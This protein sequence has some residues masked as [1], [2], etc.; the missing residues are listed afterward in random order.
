LASSWF[1]V[2]FGSSPDYQTTTFTDYDLKGSVGT[3][4]LGTTLSDALAVLRRDNYLSLSP[5]DSNSAAGLQVLSVKRCAVI[6]T[7]PL[8]DT[9]PGDQD[10]ATRQLFDDLD[11]LVAGAKRIKVSDKPASFQDIFLFNPL[12]LR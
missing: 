4:Q 7:I 12:G 6:T 3:F 2:L 8:Y 11:K 1:W 9:G 5:H 10:P